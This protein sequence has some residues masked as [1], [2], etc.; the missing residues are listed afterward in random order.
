MASVSTWKERLCR[1]AASSGAPFSEYDKLIGGVF[2]EHVHS[3]A[4][5]TDLDAVHQSVFSESKVQTHAVVTLI[6]RPLCKPPTFR[7]RSWLMGNDKIVL[8]GILD[9]FVCGIIR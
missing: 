4:D 3:A 6:P 5:S 9:Q 8:I 1:A 7:S 2:F